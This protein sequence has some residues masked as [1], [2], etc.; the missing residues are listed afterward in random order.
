MARPL[1]N[2]EEPVE[3]VMV[4]GRK[5][6]TPFFTL[7]SA[8]LR[9][10]LMPSFS[11]SA[12]ICIALPPSSTIF[13]MASVIG[14]LVFVVCAILTLVAFSRMIKGDKEESFQ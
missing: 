6:V 3:T 12:A 5:L 7:T 1:Y 10:S 13:W 8:D 2:S 14:I 9:R 11:A 4:V